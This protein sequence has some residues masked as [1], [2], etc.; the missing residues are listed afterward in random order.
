MGSVLSTNTNNAVD[1]TYRNIL[2]THSFGILSWQQILN[3]YYNV[4]PYNWSVVLGI[5]GSINSSACTPQ[6]SNPCSTITIA[7][8]VTVTNPVSL[9]AGASIALTGT[10]NWIS[11]PDNDV[12][13]NFA[14]G[15]GNYNRQFVIPCTVQSGTYDLLTALWYDKDNNNHINQGD[16]VVSSKLTPAAL[17]ISPI[18]IK[19]ISSEIPKQFKLYQNYPNPFNPVTK[20]RFDVPGTETNPR[21]VP[22][23]L[24]IYDISGK[25]VE[26]LVSEELTP[27][28][29]EISLNGSAY[30]SGVYY[31]KLSA[32]SFSETKKMIVVK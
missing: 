25:L 23:R 6:A 26:T 7:S 24:V 5:T 31:Y 22:A 20:I 28:I 29:Y 4:S 3:H 8:N 18:G 17:V 14:Q 13:I 32:G 2:T 27:G 12:K 15:T 10:S 1:N 19:P 11:D 30:S 16:F 9:M 21:G